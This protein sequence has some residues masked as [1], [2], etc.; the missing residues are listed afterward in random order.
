[1]NKG[2]QGPCPDLALARL[3]SPGS[4]WFPLFV[5]I[6]LTGFFEQSITERD[7]QDKS[8]FP[9]RKNPREASPANSQKNP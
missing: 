8:A 2:K 5:I 1:M 6:F 7:A 4:P 9:R 3:S